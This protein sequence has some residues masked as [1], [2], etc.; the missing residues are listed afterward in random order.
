MT[1]DIIVLGSGP[2]GLTAALYGARANKKTLVLG[3]DT[4]GGQMA[5]IPKLENYPGF[6]GSGTELAEFM[7]KQAVE[8]GA[9]FVGAAAKKVEAMDAGYKVAATDGK[10]YEGTAVIIATG[11]SPKKLEIA[12]AREFAGKG[13]SYCATCDG[14]FYS[15][16]VVAVYGGGNSALNDALYLAN[17]AEKVYIIYRKP[18]FTRAEAVLVKRVEETK[19]I[20]CVFD[21]E[22][23]EVVGD[24]T[25]LTGLKT[26]VGELKADG[27]FVAIGHEA[28]TDF[29]SENY[30]R[31]HMGR[32][33]TDA[34]TARMTDGLFAAGDVRHTGKMQI[35][36]ATGWGCEAAMDAIAFLNKK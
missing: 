26:T 27:L 24:A 8:F 34:N 4:L 28:N 6:A 29:L 1:Y 3:G 36:V 17:L 13:V 25:G 14:F 35:C 18:A 30:D 5:G 33:L 19:N 2:A 15:K 11:A 9:E 12:G 21:A 22:I 32:L 7:K 20:E 10:T 23:T 31:D 16:K